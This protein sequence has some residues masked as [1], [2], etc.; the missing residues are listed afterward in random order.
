[1]FPYRCSQRWSHFPS[2]VGSRYNFIQKLLDVATMLAL[3]EEAGS[4]YVLC[5]E[6]VCPYRKVG[7]LRH[8]TGWLFPCCW[9]NEE[10]SFRKL[11]FSSLREL[12]VLSE[13]HS[14]LLFSFEMENLMS[15]GDW[16]GSMKGRKSNSEDRASRTE[17]DMLH[18]LTTA[19]STS[20][21]TTLQIVRVFHHGSAIC[22]Y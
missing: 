16:P 22:S 17:Q 18:W 5:C 21:E 11:T 19:Y 13:R 15:P 10:W 14:S 20:N 12:V 4:R 8:C 2:S 1:M 7:E 3:K 9:G 6:G